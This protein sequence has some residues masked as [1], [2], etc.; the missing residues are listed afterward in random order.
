MVGQKIGKFVT[1]LAVAAVGAGVVGGAQ[2]ARNEEILI[3]A[4]MSMTGQHDT[5]GKHS[6]RGYQ[7]A[8]NLINEMG[9]I[10]IDGKKYDLKIKY[11]DDESNPKLAAKFA[12]RLISKDQVQFMLGPY[13]TAITD[14][15]AEVSEK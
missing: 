11:Y 14:A 2:A 6:R 12:K 1:A 4:T 15:V 5:N 8:V 9:G 3:G 10:E 7:L 13:S